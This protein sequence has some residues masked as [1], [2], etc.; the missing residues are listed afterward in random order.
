M[1]EVIHFRNRFGKHMCGVLE[2]DSTIPESYPGNEYAKRYAAGLEAPFY[3]V[4]VPY[5]YTMA[6]KDTLNR[7]WYMAIVWV[8]DHA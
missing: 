3:P 7:M 8:V 2:T 4:P 1:I 6:H 5:S